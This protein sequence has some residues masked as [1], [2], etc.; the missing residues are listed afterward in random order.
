MKKIHVIAHTHWDFEWYFSA[1]ESLIQLIYHMDEVLK[2]LEEGIIDYYLLD[3]QLSILKDYLEVC[4]NKEDR[5]RKLISTGKLITGPWYT[6]TDQMIISGES[7]VRNLKIGIDMAKDLGGYMN[8]GYV[9]DSFGQSIDAPQIY[10]GMGIDKVV[11]WR[12]ITK[13]ISPYREFWWS[14]EDG[15]EVLAYNI[16][17]GYFIG[18]N[19][20]YSEDEKWL[21]ETIEKDTIYNNIPLPVGGDQRYV[22]FNLKSR[23][24]EFN[25]RLKGKYYLKES[26]YEKMFDDILAEDKPLNKI[27]GEFLYSE[28]SKIHRSIYSSRYDHKYL[29]DK[30]ERRLI[31]QVEPLMVIGEQFGIEYKNQ[32]VQNIWEVILRNHAHDSAGGCNT[33]KT[34]KVILSRYEKAEQ[35]SYSTV[36]YL[37]RKI[38]E[39]RVDSK[40]NDITIFNTLPYTRYKVIKIEVS[41]KDKNFALFDGEDKIEYQVLNRT[42]EYSGVISRNKED[43]K[44]DLYYYVTKIA[45]P[46]SLKP[47]GYKTIKLVEGEQSFTETEANVD[48]Y[49]ESEKI[50][51]ELENGKI[52]I[53]DKE[54]NKI[55]KDAIYIEESGDEGDTYDYSPP[56]NDRIYKFDFKHSI[57]DTKHGKYVDV[58]RLKGNYELPKD[59]E[60]RKKDLID[61]YVEYDLQ[62]ELTKDS[63]LIE[64]NMKINNNVKDHRMRIIFNTGIK[65]KYSYA[66]TP[67]GYI[68]RETVPKHIDDWREIGW[69]EE[70]TP[71]YPMLSYV[72]LNEDENSFTVMSKGIKEYEIVGDRKD[73]V[74]LTLFRSVGYLGRPELLRR[75]GVASGNQ[76]KY[77]ETPDSQLLKQLHFKFAIDLDRKFSPYKIKKKYI[78]YSISTP[79]YQIQEL[80]KFTNTLKYFVSNKLSHKLPNEFNLLDMD[81]IDGII[82]SAIKK[83][84]NGDGYILRL[85]NPSKEFIKNGGNIKINKTLESIEL[86]DMKEDKIESIKG[87]NIL[88]IGSF[89]PKEIKNY[90]IRM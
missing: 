8:I 19:L 37:V 7:I 67:F 51:I 70:P 60:S 69:K 82:V 21:M 58:I 1:N 55:Y 54:K 16:K 85:Y 57:I 47:M 87:S 53:I 3:G 35:M 14:S 12:G 68:R 29:N 28:D 80:N 79:Y 39:S 50:K 6:Q 32:L 88:N 77:I 34:N 33:D 64:C 72:N 9:P 5:I 73:K 30:V 11:F 75:P 65:S 84:D 44:K 89:N 59:L 81:E 71:I 18:G 23:I 41:T 43:Y 4:P 61:S 13:E 46:I 83:S 2:A 17:N 52:N 31:Y 66:D 56:Y 86:I 49:I 22:D 27:Q 42:K 26:T 63:K 36:D 76:F 20:I 48:N 74:A 25:K 10:N 90:R 38:S 62:I 45:F 24:E 40:K 78:N 15:S